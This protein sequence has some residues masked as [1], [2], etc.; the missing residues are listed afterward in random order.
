MVCCSSS[1]PDY[2][3]NIRNMVGEKMNLKK[4]IAFTLILAV[5]SILLQKNEAE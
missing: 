3:A 5:T 4:K 1:Q 2:A